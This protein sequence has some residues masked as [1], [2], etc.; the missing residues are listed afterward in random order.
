MQAKV[1]SHK[2]LI[3]TVDLKI[4]DETM[5][6]IFGNFLPTEEYYKSIRQSVWEFWQ[7]NNSDYEKWDSLGL[8]VQL[9]NGYFIFAEGGITID[10][11]QE[12]PNEPIQINI[13]GVDLRIIEE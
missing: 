7:T 11:I 3:G 10:D 5:G 13:S 2:S 4:G 6:G 12:L 1:F 9:D 8:N